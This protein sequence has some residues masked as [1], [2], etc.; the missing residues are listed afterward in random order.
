MDTGRRVCLSMQACAVQPMPAP[1]VRCSTACAGTTTTPLDIICALSPPPPNTHSCTTTGALAAAP[2]GS[3]RAVCPGAAILPPDTPPSRALLHGQ[4]STACDVDRA[5]PTARRCVA[6]SGK[7]HHSSV[8]AAGAAGAHTAP[9]AGPA[10]QW[11]DCG[12]YL[13]APDPD[14]CTEGV[15]ST[16]GTTQQQRQQQAQQWWELRQGWCIHSGAPCCCCW[17]REGA[18]W[19][20][21]LE[22]C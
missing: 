18:L 2:R 12:C 3:A 13:G 20:K 4:H 21:C 7:V 6:L 22:G 15:R 1:T 9:T 16:G 8:P 17:C 19:Q 11:A 5:A 10:V 14:A